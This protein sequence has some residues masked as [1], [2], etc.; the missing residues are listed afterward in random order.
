MPATGP[1]AGGA[2]RSLGPIFKDG[3]SQGAGQRGSGA[4]LAARVVLS[5][6]L[7]ASALASRR[8]GVRGG[9]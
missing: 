7:V 4:S 5:L 8:W 1:R 3:Q 6:G 2:T 9:G